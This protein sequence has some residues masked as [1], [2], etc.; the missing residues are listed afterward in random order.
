MVKVRDDQPTLADGR[1]D[2]AGSVDVFCLLDGTIDRRRVIETGTY[3]RGLP[4]GESLLSV[5]LAFGVLIAELELGTDAVIAAMLYRA[6][7]GRHATLADIEA[8]FGHAVAKLTAEVH[9]MAA[10]TL[11]EL[12]NVPLLARERRDQ[13]DNVRRMLVAL[14]SDARVAVLKIAERV[15]ALR[16]A[17]RMAPVRQR[18]IASEALAV[19]APL[20]NRLGIW[21][22]KWELEDLAF[23]Y[24]SPEEYRRVA[25]R[26]DGRRAEREREIAQM[27]ELVRDELARGG[28]TAK[29]EGRAKHIY[30][31]WRKMRAKAIDFSE[32]HDVRAVRVLVSTVQDCYAALGA[33]HTKWR[34]V[35]SEFD[36]YIA[37]PKDNGYR[38]IHTAVVGPDRKTLEV[39]IRTEEMHREAELGVCAH[40]TYK[41][42][43]DAGAPDS[44][45]AAKLDWLRQVLDWHDELGGFGPISREVRTSLE[46]QR[47]YVLTPRGH[48]L[49]LIVGATPVDF[50]YRVHTEI[51]HRCRGA[52]VDGKIVSL[53][54][55]LETGQ[56]IEIVTG[57][58]SEPEREWLDPQRA[59]VRTARARA[60]IQAW[61]RAL[62]MEVNVA[63][64]RAWIAAELE[65]LAMPCDLAAVAAA[66]GYP[67]GTSLALAVSLGERAVV[68]VIEASERSPLANGQLT[69]EP[70]IEPRTSPIVGAGELPLASALCCCPKAGS[71]IIGIAVRDGARGRESAPS[72][73]ALVMVHR[74]GCATV[75]SERHDVV[76]LHWCEA[77]RDTQRVRITAY[78]RPGLLHDVTALLVERNVS[79][80]ASQVSTDHRRST[81]SI[82][83]EMEIGRV[84]E[85]ARII[86]G[87]RRVPGV[88]DARRQR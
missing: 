39:Q 17:R 33:I 13:A 84:S 69:F 27:V 14:I 57:D 87:M 67:D 51:G 61:F 38:S 37:N 1:L 40:W 35:P 7:H 79:I 11:V 34:H 28:I 4:H 77:P 31:I 73:K 76:V 5:G 58:V 75:L 74:M 63:A 80:V 12:S 44:A 64:G 10:F 68:D 52:R 48:V 72:D 71:D 86:D 62:P 85:L 54:T 56:R 41:D 49:D 42:A 29:V 8:R 60:K 26:L 18:R 59:F 19:F 65:R 88:I 30:S 45:Y 3:L 78:D 66:M 21:R 81:A 23:R 36:D 9:G 70:V 22:L 2:L 25:A 50:A 15:M 20:A 32:V 24:E 53:D 46:Q 43:T 16:L 55:P 83:L 6:L 82:D 47:I